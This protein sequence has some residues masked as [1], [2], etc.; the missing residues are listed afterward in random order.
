[1]EFKGEKIIH[2][3]DDYKKAMIQKMTL[4]EYADLSNLSQV[5]SAERAQLA[6][7]N[8]MNTLMYY[9]LSP[10]DSITV[11]KN[12][13]LIAV[14]ALTKIYIDDMQEQQTEK[15]QDEFK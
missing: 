5:E 15:A 13:T 3:N 8:I 6:T 7:N 1:M 9:G 10:D 4:R 2:G 14:N 12:C 11:L